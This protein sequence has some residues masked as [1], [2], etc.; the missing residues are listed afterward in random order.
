MVLLLLIVASPVSALVVVVGIMV[1][2]RQSL[3]DDSV[4]PG[5]VK[6]IRLTMMF[7]SQ[8]HKTLKNLALTCS[9]TLME[10]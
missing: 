3:P 5:S 10:P 4:A 7:H 6:N 8:T 2:L 1:L 9:L